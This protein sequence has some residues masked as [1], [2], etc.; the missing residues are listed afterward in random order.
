MISTKELQAGMQLP[1]LSIE[2]L[3]RQHAPT[4]GCAL[5]LRVTVSAFAL[6]TRAGPSALPTRTVAM[7]LRR[8][9]AC[10]L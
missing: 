6:L 4:G 7:G 10:N 9:C 1:K 8:A 5:L 3:I 2:I